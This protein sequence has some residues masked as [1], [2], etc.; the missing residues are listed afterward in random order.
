M[1]VVVVLEAVVILL[2]FTDVILIL[3]LLFIF[4]IVLL[5]YYLLNTL[6]VS[7]LRK[8]IKSLE[9]TLNATM[10]DLQFQQVENDLLANKI[11]LAN[12]NQ[13]AIQAA[14]TKY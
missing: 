3:L 8:K 9:G 1:A 6:I 7:H 10:S 2:S 12:A 4:R 14:E 11:N 5:P 13:A